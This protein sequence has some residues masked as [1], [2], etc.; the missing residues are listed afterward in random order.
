M[1][2]LDTTFS[3]PSIG[4]QLVPNHKEVIKFQQNL[5]I[6]LDKIVGENKGTEI[7]SF[8]IWGMKIKPKGAGFH[9]D[10]SPKN[11]FIR[12]I[13]A[14]KEM[15]IAGRF[16]NYENPEIIPYSKLLDQIYDY[17]I[18]VLESLES[19]NG[20]K[21]NRIGIVAHSS[22]NDD[23]IPPGL[24][25][26]LEKLEK[27]IGHDLVK[28]ESQLLFRYQEDENSI[29]QCHHMLS[30]NKTAPEEGL[31][32]ILDW[33]EVLKKPLNFTK[34]NVFESL[35]TCMSKATDYFEKFGEGV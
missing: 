23:S 11:I 3:T 15:R 16:S 33:Q 24:N 19:I 29:E 13:Y 10:F 27:S 2:W 12:Y 18:Y 26:W 9:F 21:F 14:V 35:K 8:D 28:S 6:I 22:L 4:I 31:R 7:Q 25:D 20:F 1:P 34:K 17:L 30:F 5:L 32:L